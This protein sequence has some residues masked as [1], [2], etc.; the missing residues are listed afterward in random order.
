MKGIAAAAATPAPSPFPATPGAVQ[1]KTAI[2]KRGSSGDS[3]D[4]EE[5]K[6]ETVRVTTRNQ[7]SFWQ[8]KV[9]RSRIQEDVGLK[10]MWDGFHS[11]KRFTSISK[12]FGK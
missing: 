4:E 7:K 11:L 2:D 9:T 12:W 10:G 8:D 3:D 1:A 6:E 5:E